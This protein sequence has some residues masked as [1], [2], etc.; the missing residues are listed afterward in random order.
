[1]IKTIL[2]TGATSGI[3]FALAENLAKSGRKIIATGRNENALSKLHQLYPNNI[4][5]VTA[6][7]SKQDD[8]VKI[9]QAVNQNQTGIYIVH[10]AGIANPALL[11]NIS[12]EDW[13]QHYLVNL[14]A[15]VFLT[16]MLLPQLK[17]G[18]RILNIS[19]GVA[20]RPLIGFPAYGI[21]KAAL[22][23]MKEYC[24]VEFGKEGIAFGSA[25]PGI[26]DTP[27]QAH[28]R[29]FTSDEFPAVDLFKGFKQRDELLSPQTAAK[30]LSWLLL[31]TSKEEFIK[32]D[33]DIY[34]ASHRSHWASQGDVKERNM[35]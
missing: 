11:E 12:E 8:L 16:K 27:I 33:W 4:T 30:F 1:M 10:N 22:L 3:G 24:N 26:V 21:T 6:D 15:P 9:K 18:G 5:P 32:G 23:M 25:M 19:T 28:L 34:D 13:D 31:E 7:I 35:K 17:Q 29:E 14:K 20:H 2:I